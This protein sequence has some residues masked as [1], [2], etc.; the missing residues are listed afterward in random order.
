VKKI[1]EKIL[2]APQTNFVSY[3]TAVITSNLTVMST[4]TK[5]YLRLM[6]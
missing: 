2:F 5:A 6:L 4:E 1:F 3:L